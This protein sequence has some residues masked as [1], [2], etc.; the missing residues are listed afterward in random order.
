MH[1][2]GRDDVKRSER[3]KL[4][5]SGL[6]ANRKLPREEW[7]T[8]CTLNDE[9]SRFSAADWIKAVIGRQSDQKHLFLGR[10]ENVSC[11]SV[12]STGCKLPNHCL[13]GQTEYCL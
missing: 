3:I 1:W 7:H 9:R 6:S 8:I 11:D 12:D 5:T 4:P 10:Q 13:F 2:D